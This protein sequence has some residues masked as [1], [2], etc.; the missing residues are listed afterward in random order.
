[1]KRTEVC[2]FIRDLH[3]NREWISVGGRREGIDLC[4]NWLSRNCGPSDGK[5]FSLLH[6]VDDAVFLEVH[7]RDAGA[8]D[9]FESHYREDFIYDDC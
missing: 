4:F 8:F 6:H 1:M 7:F 3:P 9:I 5:W 2:I